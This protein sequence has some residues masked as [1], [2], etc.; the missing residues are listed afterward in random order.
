MVVIDGT[1]ATLLPG[2]EKYALDVAA[3]GRPP[4]GTGMREF[5]VSGISQYDG[6]INYNPEDRKFKGREGARIFNQMRSGDGTV[7]GIMH[8]FEQSLR[9]MDWRVEPYSQ[10]EKVS[11]PDKKAAEFLESCMGDMSGGWTDLISEVLTM[12]HIGWSWFE[13]IYKVRRG[14]DATPE[15]KYDDGLVGIRSISPRAQTTLDKWDFRRSGDVRGWWQRDPNNQSKLLY[16]PKRKSLHFRTKSE[17]NNPEGVSILRNV[18]R[19][20]RHKQIHENNRGITLERGGPGFPIAIAPINMT[21]QKAYGADSDE[22]KM[23]RLIRR[24]RNGRTPGAVV[25]YGW[26]FEIHSIG[27]GSDVLRGYLEAIA[28]C[29]KEIT[30]ATLTQFLDM[31]AS[32]SGGGGGGSFGQQTVQQ[33]FFQMSMEGWAKNIEDTLNKQLV[34]RLFHMNPSMMESLGG[35][36]KIR[37]GTVGVPNLS[38]IGNFFAKVV[39]TGLIIP[40]Y[41]L[42]VM[43]HRLIGAP[44]PSR[45]EFDEHD[46]TMFMAGGGRPDENDD[47]RDFPSR[48]SGSSDGSKSTGKRGERS[49]DR[50]R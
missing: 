25:P 27:A 9:N 2:E 39:P 42:S 40:T 49:P 45:E 16:L 19:A 33:D 7:G 1:E 26:E 30:T 15:S 11:D 34:P 10:E 12:I 43:T 46:P 13:V 36:P 23:N 28:D 8:A 18:Y 41:E 35:F 4:T 3:G 37:A 14:P 22:Y 38:Q 32:S 29:V 24:V 5:G 6:R 31:G 21:T 17:Y 50:K 20:W 48:T 44:P 47:G